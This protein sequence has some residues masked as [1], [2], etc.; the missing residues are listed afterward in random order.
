M[1]DTLI[2]GLTPEQL[3]EEE[4]LYADSGA[5]TT[6][7]DDGDGKFSLLVSFADEPVAPPK[8]E[9]PHGTD[10]DPPNLDGYVL[11]LQRLRTEQRGSL[12]RTVGVYQS[13]HDRKPVADVNGFCV[14]R[15]G[16]GD[17]SQTGV[18]NERRIVAG[19]YPLFTHAGDKNRYNTL[20]FR[21][22]GGLSLRP[23]PCIGVENTDRRSGILIHCA[24][25][26]L[27]SIGCVNLSRP[28]V[29]AQSK[30][31]YDDSRARVI[32]LISSIRDVLGD[33]FPGDNN[34]KIPSAFLVVRDEPPAGVSASSG[35]I[36]RPDAAVAG[37]INAQ[38]K[39]A[40]QTALRSNEI[41]DSSPYQLC[42]AGKGKS[43]ASFGATQGDLAANQPIVES[44]FESALQA[45]GFSPAEIHEF[46][47]A[48]SVPLI[49]DPLSLSDTQRINAAL[50]NSKSLVDAM[51][52]KILGG[53]FADVDRCI[54]AASEAG[55]HIEPKALIYMALWI[56]MTG[57]PDKLSIWLQGGD[58]GL[59]GVPVLGASVSGTDME[60]YLRSTKYFRENPGNLPHML[61]SAADGATTLA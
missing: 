51:D 13:F 2:D 57:P 61:R 20:H 46:S 54:G 50:L 5:A 58:P 55:R 47:A 31:D 19:T 22:P 59:A 17:N 40:I 53:V 7:I 36:S 35:T 42:F 37:G 48:L 4:Q 21:D 15:P 23:W 34:L 52:Q 38:L 9:L 60:G 11:V 10:I 28:L 43:G 26:F 24:A 1:A 45:A 33:H 44:T 18:D 41:G 6:S 16:P 14:E 8:T 56:N 29:N 25:G 32:A 12:R 49:S 30:L 39:S 3:K 27:M